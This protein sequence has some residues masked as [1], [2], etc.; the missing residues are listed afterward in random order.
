MFIDIQFMYILQQNSVAASLITHY[1]MNVTKKLKAH[2][3]SDI[4]RE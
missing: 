1:Y 4:V 3:E 2:F